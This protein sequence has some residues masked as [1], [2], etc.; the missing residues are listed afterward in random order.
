MYLYVAV[1]NCCREKLKHYAAFNLLTSFQQWSDKAHLIIRWCTELP[2]EI[3]NQIAGDST[4][5]SFIMC[6][7]ANNVQCIKS[8]VWRS[9]D[10]SDENTVKCLP[11]TMQFKAHESNVSA[12]VGKRSRR[13]WSSLGPDRSC[14]CMQQ[15]LWSE[16]PV[17]CLSWRR[18]YTVSERRKQGWSAMNATR[19][20]SSMTP[21]HLSETWHCWRRVGEQQSNKV[22]TINMNGK[23]EWV[24][25]AG[26][27]RLLKRYV[28]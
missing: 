17:R 21:V 7:T 13:D 20:V 1:S 16:Q 18:V 10:N 27:K 15:Q 3:G 28:C 14:L 25:Q 5:F 26:E 11:P 4:F 19:L 8:P 12:Q 6:L 24:Q 22:S 23:L 9:C 2:R